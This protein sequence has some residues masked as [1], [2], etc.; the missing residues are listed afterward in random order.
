MQVVSSDDD[1]SVHLSR[2]N[3]TTENS[4]SDGDQTSEWALLVDVSSLDGGLRSLESQTN[5]FVPSL[6]SLANLGLWVVVDVRLLE[7]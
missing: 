4:T 7:K 5:V 1:S 2:D 6:S 3:S